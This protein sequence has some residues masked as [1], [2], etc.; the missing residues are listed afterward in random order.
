MRNLTS[1]EVEEV[2]GGRRVVALGVAAAAVYDGI[3]AGVSAAIDAFDS[4][5]AGQIDGPGGGGGAGGR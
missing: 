5:G 2:A 1:C 4:S 3:K